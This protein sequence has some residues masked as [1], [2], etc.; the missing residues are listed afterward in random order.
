MKHG[1]KSVLVRQELT[2]NPK[3]TNDMIAKAV[4]CSTSFVR[5][6][7]SR[8]G[9]TKR[10]SGPLPKVARISQ[11]NMLWVREEAIRSRVDIHA[12]VN[13]IVTDARMECSR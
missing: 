2:K 6:T 9:L 11:E 4:G 7:R 10:P 3:R 12:L 5:S 13:A 8:M 1:E